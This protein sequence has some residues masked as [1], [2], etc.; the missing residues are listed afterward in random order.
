M[1]A[2]LHLVVLAVLFGIEIYDCISI[3]TIFI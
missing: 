2:R 3:L 1:T